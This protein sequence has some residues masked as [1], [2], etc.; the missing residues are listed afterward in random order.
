MNSLEKTDLY[1]KIHS[2][3][4]KQQEV[5]QAHSLAKSPREKGNM[6]FSDSARKLQIL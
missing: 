3:H 2:K 4:N 1:M 5:S 6:P